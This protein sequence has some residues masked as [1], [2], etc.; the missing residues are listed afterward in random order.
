LRGWFIF[1]GVFLGVFLRVFLRVFLGDFLFAFVR[2]LRFV[3]L[4]IFLPI[5]VL[6]AN[7]SYG[8]GS[9]IT[10]RYRYWGGRGRWTVVVA[11]L[12][13]ISNGNGF[14]DFA[15]D[16]ALFALVALVALVALFALTILWP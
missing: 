11:G 7:P 5:L 8:G 13:S 16:V 3:F 9:C 1:F 10:H 6:K 14:F 2:I 4:G 12:R 15:V